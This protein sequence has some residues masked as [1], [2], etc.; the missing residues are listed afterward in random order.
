MGIVYKKSIAKNHLSEAAKKGRYG[1][2]ILVHMN[3]DEA[4]VLAK[5]AGIEKLPTNP[6]TGLPEAFAF[7]AAATLALGAYSAIK[8]GKEQSQQASTQSKL[9]NQ[10]Q[11]ELD[12]ALGSLEG[13]KSSKEEVAKLEFD[14]SI[15]QLSTQT[16]Q[17]KEDLQQQYEGMVQKS[18]MATSGSATGK[19]SQVYK[20][21]QN[22][23]STGS[24]SLL[25]QLGKSM[26]GVEE[27]YEGEKS[28]LESEKKRLGFQKDLADKQSDAWYLGKNIFG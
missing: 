18:G 10:Q 7:M 15:G 3:K 5:S 6:D 25:G 21:I 27:W 12:E 22:K 13:V 4:A 28:R 9:I 8:G 19:M 2:N 14:Q 26:A 20:R 23:F 11:Q 16:G 17:S 24:A 1:D